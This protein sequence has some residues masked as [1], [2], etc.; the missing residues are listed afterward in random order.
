MKS[1]DFSFLG[2]AFVLRDAQEACFANVAAARQSTIQRLPKA[3]GCRQGKIGTIERM[4]AVR[5]AF[6]TPE[7]RRY[8]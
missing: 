3:M 1:I 8:A 4:D 2:D 6:T 7:L 5:D